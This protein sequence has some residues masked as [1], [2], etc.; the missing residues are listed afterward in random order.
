MVTAVISLKNLGQENKW[1]GTSS[2]SWSSA[3]NWSL[4]QVPNE[5]HDVVFDKSVTFNQSFSDTIRIKSFTL[6][7]NSILQTLAPQYNF[8]LYGEGLALDIQSGSRYTAFSGGFIFREANSTAEIAG[9]MVLT[10]KE[11]KCYLNL[12]NTRTTVSGTLQLYSYW[13]NTGQWKI[14]STKESLFFENGSIFSSDDFIKPYIP[15]AT[16]DSNSLCRVRNAELVPDGL[17]QSFGNLE[18]HFT[19]FGDKIINSDLNVQGNLTMEADQG[20]DGRIVFSNVATQTTIKVGGNFNGGN[21][22]VTLV[23]GSGDVAMTV[24]GNFTFQMGLNDE[25]LTLKNGSGKAH[26]K[27][28]GNYTGQMTMSAFAGDTAKAE[29][30]GN[31]KGAI[32]FSSVANGVGHLKLG[33]NLDS[34]AQPITESGSGNSLGILE[35]NGTKKQLLRKYGS[36]ITNNINFIVSPGASLYVDSTNFWLAGSGYFLL[37]S[38]A[39]LGIKDK[40]G[41]SIAAVKG[42]VRVTGER[43][44]SNNASY[45]FYGKEPQET[46]DGIKTAATITVDNSNGYP[47]KLTNDSIQLNGN[48]YLKNGGLNAPA[49]TLL[50][51]G[52]WINDSGTDSSLI[53]VVVFNGDSSSRIAGGKRT[54]FG[55]LTVDKNNNALTLLANDTRVNKGLVLGS[56]LQLNSHHFTLSDTAAV[57]AN[58]GE[59]NANKMIIADSSGEFR[60]EFAVGSDLPTFLFPVGNG[61]TAAYSPVE[62]EFTDA[63]STAGTIGVSLKKSKHPDNDY[64]GAYL[65]GFWTIRQYGLS[66]FAV[67]AGFNYNDADVVGNESDLQLGKWDGTNWILYANSV[68][69]GTNHLQSESISSF[70]D[71]TGLSDAIVPPFAFGTITVTSGASNSVDLNFDVS[72]EQEVVLYEIERSPGTGAYV[73]LGEIEPS[74]ANSYYFNDNAPLTGHNVYRIRAIKS[75]GEFLYSSAESI[76]IGGINSGRVMNI[77]PNPIQG[78]KLRILFID[79]QPGKYQLTVT[80]SNGNDIYSSKF[81]ATTT[82]IQQEIILNGSLPRGIYRVRVSNGQNSYVQTFMK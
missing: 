53:P 50:I 2:G 3:T 24:G 56:L 46:G 7:N 64:S 26:L 1:I 61:G 36:Y 81:E 67:K 49:K 43:N 12:S 47:L 73:K 59:Y 6:K 29:I 37:D 44:F 27:V 65:R 76:E 30:S 48:L 55:K 52:D 82:T 51:S 69:P 18:M 54:G 42:A 15:V 11:G 5:A 10:E 33:G 80:G 28:N 19:L 34:I 17:D 62:I 70:S 13:G 22:P 72:N 14:Q 32:D 21:T 40:D 35:F 71:F 41:V 31:Y 63:S 16:W 8:V 25:H 9:T 38:N 4:G 75:N 78:N 66:D 57:S 79:I 23:N 77:Y 45:V 20:Y 60:K 68:S 74:G 58:G 39:T